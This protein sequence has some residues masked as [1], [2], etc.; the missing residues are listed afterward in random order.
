M[1]TMSGNE[2]H[3]GSLSHLVEDTQP[4]HAEAHTSPGPS[5]SLTPN[6]F[7]LL[8]YFSKVTTLEALIL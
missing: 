5:V 8:I 3:P 6:A 1:R 7:L 4:P 2:I